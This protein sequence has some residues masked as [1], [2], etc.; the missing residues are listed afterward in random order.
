MLV[1]AGDHI[2]KAL[3]IDKANR[4]RSFKGLTFKVLLVLDNAP[5]PP[6]YLQHENVDVVFKPKNTT[7]LRQPLDQGIISTFKALYIKRSFRYI[8]DHV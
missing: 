5:G 4:P 6:Q 3:V 8:L 1:N 7:A 2:M